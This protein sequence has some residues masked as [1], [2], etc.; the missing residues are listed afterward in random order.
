M[1]GREKFL[2]LGSNSFSGATMQPHIPLPSAQRRSLSTCRTDLPQRPHLH[3]SERAPIPLLML[4][5]K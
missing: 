5:R 2:I 4:S 1:A 3:T